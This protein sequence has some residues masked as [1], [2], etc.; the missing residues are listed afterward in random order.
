MSGP[1]R[2]AEVF[3][4]D[5]VPYGDLQ[6]RNVEDRTPLA[7]RGL[8]VRAAL[9][10]GAPLTNDEFDELYAA[11]I[12]A[13]S[14]VYWTPLEVAV[15][16][17]KMLAD[18]PGCRVL[19]IGSGAGK[20]CVVGA[21][22]TEGEF[23]GVEQQAPLVECARELASL[24]GATNATFV[25]GA[26]DTMNPE[27]FDAFYFF[28]PFEE[29]KFVDPSDPDANILLLE[30]RFRTDVRNAQRFLRRARKGTRVLTYNGMGGRIPRSYSLLDRVEMRCTVELWVNDPS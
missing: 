7:A 14:Q 29:N 5:V 2:R 10:S 28:N 25:H 23:V 3:H 17:A 19:D 21:L 18:T 12:R 26:F 20:F 4:R 9:R 27:D 15:R 13:K 30:E 24:V 8:N 1:G 11:D 6:L 16:T 22:V